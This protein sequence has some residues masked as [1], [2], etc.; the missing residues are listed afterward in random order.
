MF[1]ENFISAILCSVLAA[2]RDLAAE[3]APL[4]F[5]GIEPVPFNDEINTERPSFSASPVP[6]AAGHLQLESGVQFTKVDRDA[7]DVTF[8]FALVRA[9]LSKNVELQVGWGGYSDTEVGDQSFEGGNDVT[10]ALKTQLTDQRGRFRRS[11]S[12]DRFRYQQVRRTTHRTP[13][14]RLSGCCGLTISPMW[15]FSVRRC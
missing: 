5:L 10:V 8:P 9:G 12:W 15:D 7:E 11:A 6:L 14:T 13:S 2:A 1:P 3:D 4:D